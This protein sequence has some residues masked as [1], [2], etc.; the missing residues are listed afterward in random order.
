MPTIYAGVV[1]TGLTE[2]VEAHKQLAAQEGRLEL[3]LQQLADKEELL[4]QARQL[5][6]CFCWMHADGGVQHL[7]FEVGC[8]VLRGCLGC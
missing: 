2:V 8:W 3:L 1:H 7:C 6:S 5:V 4:E